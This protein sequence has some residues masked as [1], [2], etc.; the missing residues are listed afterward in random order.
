MRT[1]LLALLMAF[2]MP[3]GVAQAASFDCAKAVTETEKAI[4]SDPALSALDD[5]LG[6][7]WKNQKI[8]SKKNI[9]VQKQ[10]LVKRDTCRLEWECIYTAYR[11]FLYKLSGIN[12]TLAGWAYNNEI[13]HPYCFIKEWDSSDNFQAYYEHYT[14]VKEAYYNTKSYESF[15]ENTGLFFGS[16]ITSY[17]PIKNRWD[18]IIELAVSMDSCAN[19]TSVNLIIAD[20]KVSA[21]ANDRDDYNYEIVASIG[22]DLCQKLAPNI[23]GTCE[24]SYVLKVADWGGGSKGHSVSFM[25]YGL[26]NM[27]DDKKYIIP[28]KRFRQW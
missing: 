22:T 26:F 7:I 25:L 18:E 6:F 8:A 2:T 20:Q 16:I 27:V 4:C 23:I 28:L 12:G 21:T 1:I 15:S 24:E 5:I 3:V 9:A 14:G 11:Q 10:W 19:K 13:L 17:E